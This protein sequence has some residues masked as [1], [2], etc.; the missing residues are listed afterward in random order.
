V[1]TTP[2]GFGTGAHFNG[3]TPKENGSPGWHPRSPGEHICVLTVD[4]DRSFTEALAGVIRSF[5]LDVVS[6]AAGREALALARR[7]RFDLLLLHVELRDIPSLD[8]VRSLRDQ[9]F[10]APF[11]LMMD[12]T[13]EP[14]ASE[15]TALGAVAILEEPI[16]WDALRVAVA[17]AANQTAITRS[18]PVTDGLSDKTT[19]PHGNVHID[20]LLSQ[21]CEPHNPCE[22][23]RNLV[24]HLI[25]AERDLKTND[26]WAKHAAVS[27]SV[28]CASCRRVNLL[29]RDT[30]N[31]GRMLRALLRVGDLWIPETVLDCDDLRTLRNLEKRSGLTGR[32]NGRTT[33]R[34]PSL[35]EFFERQEW[36]PRDNPALLMLQDLL[37]GTDS[38]VRSKPLPIDGNGVGATPNGR[39]ETL[40]RIVA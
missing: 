18:R 28:L 9:G 2:I 13:T 32:R 7:V 39:D 35:E 40:P 11:I 37:L 8:L 21:V 23:W 29:T 30:R 10:K 15:A 33:L 4:H 27:R 22:R 31:L 26:A 12:H 36:I 20:S 34:T 5:G 38:A 25:T 14:V 3:H 1:V 24:L 6:A 17:R 16:R 19:A